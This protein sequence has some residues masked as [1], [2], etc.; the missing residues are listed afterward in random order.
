MD[1]QPT[2][3]EIKFLASLQSI[4]GLGPASLG[5]LLDHF[6]SFARV[7][8]AGPGELLLAGLIEA[9][10]QR[11]FKVRQKGPPENLMSE[12]KVKNIAVVG[13]GSQNYPPGLLRLKSAPWLLFYRGKL[14]YQTQSIAIV[15]SRHPTGYGREV[16]ATFSRELVGCGFAIV[17]GL[18]QGIDQAAHQAALSSGGVT[19]A[20]LGS[21]ID[22][23]YPTFQK[24]LAEMIV[25]QGG[26]VLSEYGLGMRPTRASF[27]ARN[28]L[29]AALSLGVI[30]VE[31][32]FCSGA[33]NTAAWAKRM[34]IPV[35]AVPGSITS[36]QSV[37]CHDLIRAGAKLVTCSKDILEEIEK[38]KK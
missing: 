36:D 37:G 21:G 6:G 3:E 22:R 2:E 29:I 14:N 38:S 10:G 35:L 7:W 30:V 18:A 33:K 9:T 20:V 13:K 26:A 15:G 34:K 11:I 16:A 4:P 28:R 8:Q 32:G 25:A 12:L 17:S 24:K 27:P 1:W 31:A 19:W 23:I 5:K